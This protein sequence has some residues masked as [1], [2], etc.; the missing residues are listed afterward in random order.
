VDVN[1]ADGSQRTSRNRER[2][3]AF[4][5]ANFGIANADIRCSRRRRG[6][7]H[8]A[9]IRSRQGRIEPLIGADAQPKFVVFVTGREK[10]HD[11]EREPGHTC[12][13]HFLST[14]LL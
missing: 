6:N 8:R 14:E 1:S 11:Y 10:R 5:L 2:N 13:I 7:R 12:E 9:Y 3:R 4:A